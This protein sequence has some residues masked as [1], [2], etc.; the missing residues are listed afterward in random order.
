MKR[1]RWVLERCALSKAKIPLVT[2]GTFQTLQ[3]I[4][5]HAFL[6]ERSPAPFLVVC[7]LSVLHNW[8]AE[9][10]K[11]APDVRAPCA[12]SRGQCS[13]Y[14]GYQC[15]QI[16]VVVYHGSPEEREELRHTKMVIPEANRAKWWLGDTPAVKRPTKGKGKVNGKA[17]AAPA[18]K[19]APA[20]KAAKKK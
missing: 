4:A 14:C 19:K 20:K 10:N 7:P 11:F 9:F 8:A 16:P 12:S 17:K 15:Y 13:L 1:T 5:F 2:D 3:T 6:R 18:P